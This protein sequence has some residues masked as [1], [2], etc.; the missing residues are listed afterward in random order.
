MERLQ[1]DLETQTTRLLMIYLV[2]LAAVLTVGFATAA[3]IARS[4]TGPVKDLTETAR[5]LGQ[6]V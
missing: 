5:R 2:L 3:A 1:K 6:G 4:V